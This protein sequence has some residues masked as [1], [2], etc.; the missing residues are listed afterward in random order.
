M[1][2][3]FRIS[4][5]IASLMIGLAL[6]YDLI[7]FLLSFILMGW[8]VALWSFLTFWFWFTYLGVSYMKPSKMQGAKIASLG[9][10]AILGSLPLI[11]ALPAETLGVSTNIAAIYAEDILESIS[12]EALKAIAKTIDNKNKPAGQDALDKLNSKKDLDLNDKETLTRARQAMDGHINQGERDPVVLAAYERYKK[13][14]RAFDG[15]VYVDENNNT[16]SGYKFANEHYL[17][18]HNAV[19][20]HSSQRQLREKRTLENRKLRA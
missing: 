17:G 19:Y 20:E 14:E 2:Q 13:G 6:I 10:P 1:P 8:I 12:P 18:G 11:S 16:T 9:L 3:K 15:T 4:P 7:K 5:I